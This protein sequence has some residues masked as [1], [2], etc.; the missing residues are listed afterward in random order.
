VSR[1]PRCTARA[2]LELKLDRL[3]LDGESDAQR[4]AALHPLARLLSGV[5]DGLA[6]QALTDRVHLG[7]D[8]ASALLGRMLAA[9]LTQLLRGKRPDGAAAAGSSWALALCPVYPAGEHDPRVKSQSRRRRDQ[10]WVHLDFCDLGVG[11]RETGEGR[12][13]PCRRGYVERRPAA[14]AIQQ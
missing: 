12:G 11:G 2:H 7:I 10:H 8:A 9:V 3:G 6:I 13:D 5:V 14:R 4:R 1:P